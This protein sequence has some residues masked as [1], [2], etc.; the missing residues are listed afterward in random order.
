MARFIVALLVFTGASVSAF[1]QSLPVPSYWL[2]QRGSELKVYPTTPPSPG[3]FD[4][5]YLNHA[6]GFKCQASPT[7]PPYHVT[8]RIHGTHVTFKVIWNN[9]VEDCKSTTLWRGR[10]IGRTMTTHWILFGPAISPPLRGV[11]IFQQQP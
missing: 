8:G 6:A 4:G 9:G 7:N 11:D 5:V 10:V 3:S 2:N 1:A